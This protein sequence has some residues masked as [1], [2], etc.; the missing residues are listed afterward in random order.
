MSG[1]R[2]ALQALLESG[3]ELPRPMGAA[4]ARVLA[5]AR[6]T[7]AS[8]PL[9]LTLEPVSRASFAARFMAPA[10]AAALAVGIAGTVYALNGAW[11][12]PTGSAVV[13]PAPAPSSAVAPHHAPSAKAPEAAAPEP[14][15]PRV[16]PRSAPADKPSA[17]RSKGT[18]TATGS[19][20]A[21]LELLRSAHTASAAHDYANSLVLVGE[22]A[23]RFPNGAL[24]EQ[25]EALR[26]RSLLGVNRTGEARRAAAAFAARFPRSVLLPRLQAEVGT[27][28]N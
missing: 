15:A 9:Q 2:A 14:V 19:Y 6:A 23:R 25:R 26:V 28:T 24:A 20:D 10:G 3:K 21:E 12:R 7:A 11:S 8:P 18:G 27:P 5:R 22:H 16:E 4:R 13:V 17:A 1:G